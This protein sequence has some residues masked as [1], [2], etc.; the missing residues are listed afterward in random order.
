MNRKIFAIILACTFA[1]NK[2]PVTTVTIQTATVQRRDIVVQ[3]E[4]TGVIEPI[5]VVEVKS[6]TASGQVTD[7]N[8]EVG[9]YV[10]PG[11]LIV[12][13]DTTDLHTSLLQNLSDRAAA[14][15]SYDVAKIVLERN[16]SL[17]AQ[18]VITK[19]VLE[20]SQ[21]SEAS[22]KA[23]LLQRETQVTLQL[24]KLKDSRVVAAAEGTILTRPVAKGQVV[25]AGSGGVS[26]GTVIATMADLSKVRARAL[27]SET[28]IGQVTVGQDAVVLVDA[29]PDRAFNGTVSKIEPSAVVQQNVTMFPVLITLDNSE[30]LLRPGMNGEVNVRTNERQQVVTVPN[31]AIRS[32]REYSDAALAL[33]LIPDSVRA[34][35]MPGRGGGGANG[36][37]GRGSRGGGGGGPQATTSRVELDLGMMQ[38]GGAQGGGAQGGAAGGNQG[39]GRR[40]GAQGDSAGGGRRGGRGPQVEVTDADCK[41]IDDALKAKPALAKKLADIQGQMRDQNADRQALNTQSEAVYKELGLDAAK[42]RSC[43]FR[44]GGG[45]GG[46]GGQQGGQQGAQGGSNF[47]GGAGGFGGGGGGGGGRRGAGGRG[48]QG[49]ARRVDPNATPRSGLVFVQKG[50]TWEP[51]LLR[52]GIANY[53]FTEVQSGVEENEKVALMSAAILQLRRQQQMDRTKAMAS[54]LGGSAPGGGSPGGSPGGGRGGAPG[55]GGGRGN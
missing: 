55:G 21:N 17:Y 28:E 20:Q 51:R 26:A 52:L 16:T 47:A 4:A 46:P 43:R 34:I 33:G 37:G 8:I 41:K 40:G 42:A 9:S 45:R 6:K 25:Q 29:F 30:G 2:P 24:Q 31:D 18:R 13:I 1:C 53:D 15:S 12:Q 38:G 32:T 48:G 7:M 3:A 10:R 35:A 5:T 22:S 50:T 11:D 36:G 19:D 23:T 14:Q 49:G 27:V 44:N 54:P 39:G